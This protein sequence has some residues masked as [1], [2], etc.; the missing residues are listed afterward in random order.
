MSQTL[1]VSTTTDFSG[2]VLSPVVTTIDFTNLSGTAARAVFSGAQI[3]AQVS[4]TVL[5]DGSAG[6]NQLVFNLGVASTF[7][8]Q[9][10]FT[11]WGITDRLTIN[12]SG[13][14]D[15]IRGVAVGETINGGAGKDVIFGSAGADTLIGANGDDAITYDLAGQE[16]GDRVDGRNGKDTLHIASGGAYDFSTT[17]IANTEILLISPIAG[18]LVQVALLGS[19]VGGLGRINT[20]QFLDGSTTLLSIE[21]NLIDFSEVT[22]KQWNVADHSMTLIGGDGGASIVG[23]SVGENI[24]GG[25]GADDLSGGNGND[26]LRSSLGLDHQF[27]DAGTDTFV[28]NELS[29]VQAGEIYDGNQQRDTLDLAA[30]PTGAYDF[31]GVTVRNIE[32]LVLNG[33]QL[34]IMDV[35]AFGT[36]FGID[37]VY[38]NEGA[39]DTLQISGSSIDI[40]DVR[41]R[42]W[43]AMDL[44]MLAGT[45]GDDFIGSTRARDLMAG[46]DGAD[47][48][49]FSDGTVGKNAWRD[50]IIDF[51][52]GDDIVNLS[53]I[54]ADAISGNGDNAFSVVG[55]Y[56]GV[57]GQL[58]INLNSSAN[59]TVLAADTNGDKVTDFQ[60]KLDGLIT[61]TPAST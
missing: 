5:V 40:G 29:H 53:A 3:P 18:G 56:T 19:Q 47:E 14:A 8:P 7:L 32:E 36:G 27:G 37:T 43:D 59:T 26:S 44:V 39:V 34:L 52:S 45:D 11:N 17:T 25:T 54:D 50:Q 1:L 21:G 6:N 4:N 15:T 61:F 22:I 33:A 35:G 31:T 49:A 20:I 12:G 28:I 23:S 57:R 2:T 55:A 51:K 41:F 13:D 24:Y 38:G 58:L 9:F 60:I 46:Q 42:L 10:T 48:F 30:Q 16:T